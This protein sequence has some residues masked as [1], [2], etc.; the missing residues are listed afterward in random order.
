[1]SVAPNAA[2][3]TQTQSMIRYADTVSVGKRG[4]GPE[5][6]RLMK[7]ARH[8]VGQLPISQ[9]SSFRSAQYHDHRPREVSRN[10][11]KKELN[12]L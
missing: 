5:R 6:T 4:A 3:I 11:V 1:M 2:R 8:T 7:M 12:V 9:L 10:E